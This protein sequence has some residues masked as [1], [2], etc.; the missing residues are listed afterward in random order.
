MGVFETVG[1]KRGHEKNAD[2]T[3]GYKYIQVITGENYF[4][5]STSEG[6]YL[7]KTEGNIT[8]L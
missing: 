4:V 3:N 6:N 8:R 7:E 1:F 5:H 2:M